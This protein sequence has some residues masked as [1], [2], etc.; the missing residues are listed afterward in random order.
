MKSIHR[1]SRRRRPQAEEVELVGVPHYSQGDAD[2]LCVYYATSML[3]AALNPAYAAS[4]HEAPRYMRL[5]SPVFRGLRSLYASDRQYTNKL[6]DWFFRGMT[7]P[8]ATKILNHIFQSERGSRQVFFRR[9]RVRA[10]R[11]GRLKYSR[12]RRSLARIWTAN[13]VLAAISWHLPVLVAGGGVGAHAVVAIGYK[14]RG[15]SERL[16]GYL[17]PARSRPEWQPCGEVF[18][19]DAEIIVPVGEQFASYRPVQVTKRGATCAFEPWSAELFNRWR[20]QSG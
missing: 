12:K 8:E 14:T 17:D 15:N 2:S 4:I 20:H 1:A 5:G 13:D 19:G 16:I 7:I 6:A 18:T 3:L 11:V 10:R 9:H